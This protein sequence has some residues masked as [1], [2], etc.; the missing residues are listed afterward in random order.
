MNLIVKCYRN[1]SVIF[2]LYIF[3]SININK[4]NLSFSLWYQSSCITLTYF[5]LPSL[6]ISIWIWI[7]NML[8]TEEVYW[9]YVWTVMMCF[10]INEEIHTIDPVIVCRCMSAV[11]WSLWADLSLRTDSLMDTG[12]ERAQHAPSRPLQKLQLKHLRH[13]SQ[14]QLHT[15]SAAALTVRVR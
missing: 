8:I 11:S 5:T 3:L 9:L 4:P 15:V 10:W 6:K 12:Y 7:K 13:A 1:F 14:I 2:F